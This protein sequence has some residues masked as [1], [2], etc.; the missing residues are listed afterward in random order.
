MAV[1]H[2]SVPVSSFLPAHPC[3]PLGNVH[4]P[5][6]A[7]EW[8]DSAKQQFSMRAKHGIK[9]NRPSRGPV[10]TAQ[11]S[12]SQDILQ[13]S[14]DVSGAPTIDV[15]VAMASVEVIRSNVDSDD[16]PILITGD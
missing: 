16:P 5:I 13:R 7:T 2:L 14:S 1:L 6:R 10:T 9:G 11:T 3:H 4:D 12:G 8:L 15:D